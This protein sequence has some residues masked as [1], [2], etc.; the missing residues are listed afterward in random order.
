MKH[1][2]TFARSLP[3][4]LTGLA[5]ALGALP[6]AAADVTATVAVHGDQPGAVID[7]HIY[8]QFAEHLGHGIYNGIWVGEKSSIPNT[9]G[10]RN[11]VIAALKAVRVPVIRWP[12]GCFADEYDW[13]DGI[14]PRAK[15][16]KR[17]NTTWGGVEE[18]NAVGT[19]EFMEFTELVGADAYIAGNMGSGSPRDMAQWVEYITS[20]SHSTLADERRANGRDQPWKLSYVGVG[21]EV[22]GCG[23]N[24]RPEY[25]ADLYRRYQSFVKVPGDQKV[26]RIASGPN[27]GDY[28]FTEVMM[29][30]VSKM[31]DGL[32]LHYY[33]IPTGVWKQ[34][35]SATAFGEDQWISTLSR[36][37]YMDELVTKHS[38]I[39][40]KYDPEKK[41]ALVVDEWGVWTDV[42]PGTNPGFLYQQ[43]SLR[44]ALVAAV[45]L[46]IFHAHADRVR[47]ANVAQMVNVLQAM[48][49]TDGPRMVLTPTYHVFDLY[50]GFQGATDLPLNL[51]APEYKLGDVTVPMLHGT[52]A[53]D[54][55][56]VVHV[57]LVNLDPH[58]VIDVR[59]SLPG[60]SASTVAGRILTAPA[61]NSVNTFDHPDTVRPAAFTGASLDKGTLGLT[62]PAK[63]IVV[64]DLK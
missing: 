52:A 2:H 32:S 1:L 20:P 31:M 53:R 9:H 55:Q 41:V 24:M 18:D 23:G 43:N 60:I 25:A 5:T 45:T 44:D 46:D 54:A 28:N 34:K 30:E 37:L 7:R 47:M 3:V 61:I 27:E 50:K 22:W 19:N 58:R 14:G 40:D 16:P 64:L 42:E 36:A 10:F 63:S 33:T 11:D 62:L 35:G 57:A 49:L 39:M 13:R 56:G 8:G 6:A 12:G 4:L 48:I 51:N 21:N 26:G 38:A 15:R 17:V 29:R 59:A